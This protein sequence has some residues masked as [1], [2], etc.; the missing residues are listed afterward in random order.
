MFSGILLLLLSQ[1]SGNKPTKCLFLS[2]DTKHRIN[3]NSCSFEERQLIG[4]RLVTIEQWP[5]MYY[6]K[7]VYYFD[8]DLGEVEH[9]PIKA[10]GNSFFLECIAKGARFNEDRQS[11]QVVFLT[12]FVARAFQG[13]AWRF[14]PLGV[15]LSSSFNTFLGENSTR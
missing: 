4:G 1:I 11:P 9:V 15:L 2:K 12:S 6:F 8:G 14:L 3:R 5:E 13:W 10:I 7:R